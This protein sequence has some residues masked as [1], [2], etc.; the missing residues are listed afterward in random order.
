MQPM[1]KY[2]KFVAL[3]ISALTLIFS[4]ISPAYA[5][6]I[7]TEQFVDQ[8][9]NDQDR[10]TLQN[11]LKREEAKS[12]LEKYGV[13]PE[14]AQERINSLTEDEAKTFAQRF[15]ELPAGGFG[16]IAAILIIVLLFI[17]LDLSGKTD[18]FKGVGN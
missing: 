7:G 3:Y 8:Q 1:Y 4:P 11:V 18:V 5:G 16:A 13:T 14:Q 12:L 17:A 2:L 15:E 6:F 10:E 9:R